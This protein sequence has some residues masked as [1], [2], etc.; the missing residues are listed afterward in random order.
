MMAA[1]AAKEPQFRFVGSFTVPKVDRWS[2]VDLLEITHV[3][4]E[5]GVNRAVAVR[6]GVDVNTLVPLICGEY[7]SRP[8]V[9]A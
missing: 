1:T 4:Y 9:N 7:V 5:V 6:L 2:T 3:R 8:Q